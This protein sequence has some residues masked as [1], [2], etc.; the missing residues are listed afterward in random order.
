MR[1]GIEVPDQDSVTSIMAKLTKWQEHK[2]EVVA[3]RCIWFK[4]AVAHE[5]QVTAKW[6]EDWQLA[7]HQAVM[8]AQ[9]EFQAKQDSS[10][11]EDALRLHECARQMAQ[12][13]RFAD[14]KSDA[15]RDF[16]AQQV[17]PTED[18]TNR[19]KS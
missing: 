2:G 15:K 9:E 12:H 7:V 16:M 17:F 14:A 5:W 8:E 1:V 6:L 19:R 13:E 18:E 4:E 3:L 10:A 11:K